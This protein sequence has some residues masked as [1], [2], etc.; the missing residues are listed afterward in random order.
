MNRIKGALASLALLVGLS[1]TSFADPNFTAR[2]TGAQEAPFP[3]VATAAQ[4]TGLFVLSP[5]GVQFF[6]TVEGLS[7]PIIAADFENAPP[8]MPGASVRDI[9]SEFG[10]THS[11][12]GFWT[13]S[14]AQALTATLISELIKGNLCVNIHTPANPAGEIRGQV[15]LS[16]GVHFTANLQASQENP[17]TGA[18]GSGVGSFTLTDDGLHYKITLNGLGAPIIGA[19]IRIAPIGVDAG[20]TFPIGATFVGNSAEGFLPLTPAERMALIAGNMYVNIETGLFPAGQIR[21]QINLA[22]GFGFS[23][24]LD[25]GQET[26]PNPTLGLGTASA[27]LTS[28]GL[29][30][31]LTASGLTGPITAAHLH[32]GPLGFPGPVVRDIMPDFTSPTTAQVLWRSDDVMAMTPGLVKELLNNNIYVNLHTA[33]FPGGEIR[34]QLILDTPA[35]SPMATYTADLTGMQEEPP[36][37]TL[38]LGTG[39]FQLTPGGL[40]FRVTVDGLAGA[41]TAAHFHSGAIGVPGP[42]V[43]AIVAGE[44]LGSNTFAGAWTP[45]DPSPF[46]AAMMT[47]LFKGNIYFN[48]HTTVFPGGEIRGQLLPASGAEFEALL[49]GTQ[50]TPPNPAPALATGSFTL[51]PHGLAFNITADGLTGA[52]VA[53]HFHSGQ[54]GVAGPVVRAFAPGEFVTPN[55]LA[56]VWK[57]TDASPLTPALV[58]E[59]LKGNVYVNLHTAAFPAGEIRGQLT[60]SG[61][62]A[63]GAHPEGPQETPPTPSPGKGISAMT[64]TDEGH[65]FRYSANDMTG[66]PTA[67]HFHNAPVGA[68]GPVVRPIYG[69]ETLGS[70]SADGVWKTSDPDPLTTML[71]GEMVTGNLYINL[72]TAVFPG[73]EI[74]GQIGSPIS[75]VGVAE[76]PPSEG[77]GLQLS[78]APNPATNG[79]AITFFLPRR[80][81]VSLRVYDVAGSEVAELVRGTREGGWQ[82]V[83]FDTGR[84]STGLY[85]LNLNAGSSRTSWKM[86]VIR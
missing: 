35:P 69:V 72:H 47:E 73:G 66:L 31:D 24:R 46:T 39:S 42:V 28:S 11:A 84:L 41:I 80:S 59:L 56:G 86:L 32:D 45:L 81:A 25:S 62:V 4:G 12:V 60:L 78:S 13:P 58:T 61:G 83:P 55:T 76:P 18:P 10:G 6:I 37:G 34:G 50:E 40:T 3:G 48:V 8:G 9:L 68:P 23:I 15:Q 20:I 22:G 27:T 30:L 57:P 21:G 38:G 52:I 36:V 75:T 53:A 74:R 5:G 29:R 54:R 33:A 82:H 49:A 64:L 51:T 77:S 65:V 79:T 7:G 1:S 70:E 67:A 17:P 2:L 43:R 85:F 63:E 26:P 44:F 19:S 16:S 14:D 71:L